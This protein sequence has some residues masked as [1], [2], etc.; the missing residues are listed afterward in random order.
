MVG[1]TDRDFHSEKN[2]AVSP[3]GFDHPFIMILVDVILKH[4]RNISTINYR[5]EFYVR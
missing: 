4:I 5:K 2:D 1:N 3:L